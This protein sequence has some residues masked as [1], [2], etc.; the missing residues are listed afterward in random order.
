MI[1]K[2]KKVGENGLVSELMEEIE[3]VGFKEIFI[4]VREIINKKIFWGG[5]GLYSKYFKNWFDK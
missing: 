4:E 5:G 1:I 3:V 2:F